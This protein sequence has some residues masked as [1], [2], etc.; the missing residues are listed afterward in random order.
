MS[1]EES[2]TINR[3]DS[4][5]KVVAI[6]QLERGR[7]PV[8]ERVT[9]GLL[10]EVERGVGSGGVEAW[11]WVSCRASWAATFLAWRRR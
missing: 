8:L 9:W 3:G 11:T 1:D 10:S 7:R 5:R 4:G 6:T 2:S